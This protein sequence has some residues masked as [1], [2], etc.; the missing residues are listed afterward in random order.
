MGLVPAAYRSLAKL[1]LEASWFAD[2]W[3]HLSALAVLE[4]RYGFC[5]GPAAVSPPAPG[6]P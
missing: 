5:A 6:L 3:A 1:P 4:S 2:C